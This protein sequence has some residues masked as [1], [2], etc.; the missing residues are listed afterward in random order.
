MDYDEFIALNRG[1][2]SIPEKKNPG[3]Q[4]DVGMDASAFHGQH[5][6]QVALLQSPILRAARSPYIG[7]E[8]FRGPPVDKPHTRNPRLKN[9]DRRAQGIPQSNINACSEIAG[10]P[11]A[12]VES[13]PP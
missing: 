1:L 10:F 9:S 11:F 3:T 6:A 13:F 4:I 12:L 2:R 5:G 8:N 7:T